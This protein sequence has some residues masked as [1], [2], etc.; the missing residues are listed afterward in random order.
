MTLITIDSECVYIVMLWV[1]VKTDPSMT[2]MDG[3]NQENEKTSKKSAWDVSHK[4][5][6]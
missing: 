6:K 1:Y 4:H 3:D 5:R 2:I